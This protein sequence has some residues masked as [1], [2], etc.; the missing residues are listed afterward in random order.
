MESYVIFFLQG[1]I[2]KH[3]A[4]TAVIE[5]I[6]KNYSDKKIIVICQYR[7]VFLNNPNVYR[8]FNM[9]NAWYL[10]KDFIYNKNSVFLSNDP[11]FSN[12]YI[13]TNSHIIESWFNC[14][15]LSYKNEEPKIYLTDSEI[16][17]INIKYRKNKEAIIFQPNGGRSKNYN[18]N[19]IKD[20]P[21]KVAQNII[22]ELSQ[23]YHIYIFGNDENI[24]YHNA[25]YLNIPI[26]EAFALLKITKR[27]LLID[28]FAQHAC[29][30]LNTSAVVNW[31]ITSPDK[32]GYKDNI[33]IKTKLN[34]NHHDESFGLID[35]YHTL[36]IPVECCIDT[37][38]SFKTNEILSYF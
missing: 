34:F 28:S 25:E 4:A 11:Y 37:E 35:K 33:N 29:K 7:D 32:L 22:N 10:Y 8:V 13:N 31:V 6:K 20:F 23:K 18:Y 26:R 27:K 2:G 21:P 17:N 36:G 24:K 30:A 5:G 14:L 3:I 19:W 1:G 9:E 12:D 16:I 38:S 15:A